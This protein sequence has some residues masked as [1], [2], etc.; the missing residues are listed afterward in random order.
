MLNIEKYKDKLMELGVINLNKLALAQGHLQRC[1]GNTK[2]RECLFFNQSDYL[3]SDRALK[4][5]FSE[6]KEPKVDWSKVKVDTPILVRDDEDEGWM[7]RYF[8]KFADGV[9]WSFCDGR[10]SWSA[11]KNNSVRNDI[12]S[13]KY[14]KLAERS[15]KNED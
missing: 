3:C 12:I 13:W 10:T 6:Y 9:V 14:A 8:A 11:S 2:C 7:N 15:E 1:D 5:L 4:W